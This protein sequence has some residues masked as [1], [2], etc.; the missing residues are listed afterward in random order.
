M[1]NNKPF[2][3]IQC[4]GANIAMMPRNPTG[5]ENKGAENRTKQQ[6]QIT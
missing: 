4:H 1:L 3:S 6:R 5:S 2:D